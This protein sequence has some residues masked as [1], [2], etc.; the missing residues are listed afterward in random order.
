MVK[1][2]SLSDYRFKTQ[3]MC[4]QTFNAKLRDIK[5]DKTVPSYVVLNVQIAIIL[6]EAFTDAVIKS[7]LNHMHDS[8]KLS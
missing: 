4:K 1:S 8:H 7:K 5:G 6:I 2:A 3:I